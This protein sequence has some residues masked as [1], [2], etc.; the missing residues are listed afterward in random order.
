[1][2]CTAYCV[3]CVRTGVMR[4]CV[5]SGDEGQEGGRVTSRRLAV[6][7]GGVDLCRGLQ[8]LVVRRVW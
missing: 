2:L 3:C 1:M 8:L 6:D 4:P 5:R 7:D